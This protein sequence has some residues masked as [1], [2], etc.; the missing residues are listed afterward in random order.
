MHPL[1]FYNI[2]YILRK[3]ESHVTARQFSSLHED[4]VKQGGSPTSS[5]DTE[6]GG[7]CILPA[8]GS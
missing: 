5:V 2:F 6:K 3:I 4:I 7:F 1:L 8:P